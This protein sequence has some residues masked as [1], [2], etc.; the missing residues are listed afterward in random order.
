MY[1][2]KRLPQLATAHA[3]ITL[4]GSS[5]FHVCASA[6]LFCCKCSPAAQVA[7][8]SK[9]AM[10]QQMA[11]IRFK[12]FA[13]HRKKRLSSTVRRPSSTWHVKASRVRT[14][15][16]HPAIVIVQS[17]WLTMFTHAQDAKLHSDLRTE[18]RNAISEGFAQLAYIIF[19][20]HNPCIGGQ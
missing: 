7:E 16:T 19:K 12:T 10:Y 13:S 2:A 11:P 20:F 5:I 14:N 18:T 3:Y 15:P 8:Q 6:M 1:L 9:Q 4:H 17:E